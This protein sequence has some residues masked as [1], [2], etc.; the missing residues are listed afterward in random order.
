M[1]LYVGNLSYDTT[2][3][4]LREAFSKYGHV[5]SV[6]I[7]RDRY[8]WSSKGFGFVEMATDLTGER[9]IGGMNGKSVDGRRIRVSLAIDRPEYSGD[10]ERRNSFRDDEDDGR[11]G[12]YSRDD[13]RGRFSR[14]SRGSFRD[15]GPYS[16]E[17]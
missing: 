14:G 10:G 13:R 15:R 11:G 2:E 17:Y 8:T 16:D 7:M 9:A 6:L 5:I 1:R 3:D 12:R 4:T